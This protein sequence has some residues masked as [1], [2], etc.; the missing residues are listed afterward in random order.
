MKTAGTLLTT[1]FPGEKK[2]EI[3][4]S[5]SFTADA[6]VENQVV[7]LYPQAKF[8]TL[9]GF[10]GAFTDAAGYVFAQM[11]QDLRDKLIH[12]YYGPGGLGYVLGRTHLD[13]CDFSLEHYQAICGEDPEALDLT[14]GNQYI[15]PMLQ[16]AQ[17]VFGQPI[18][19][20]TAPWSPPAFMKTN[21]Q[22]NGGGA[23]RPAYYGPYAEYLSQYL[24][25]LRKAGVHVA[26]LT[27]Q[28]E[29]NAVQT[30][31]S[32]LFTAREEKTFLRDH[33]YPALQ[34]HGLT[35]VELFI[36]DHN[37][38]RIFERACETIDETTDALIAGIAFHWYSGDHFEALD[39]TQS[40]FPGKKLVQSEACI[41]YRHF[42]PADFLQNAQKYAHD[43]IGDLN[44]GMTAFYD[45]NLLLDAQGG[46]NHVGN[47]CDAPFLYHA[48]TG[49]LEERAS[50]A[51]LG[52]FTK[53]IT[54]GARR[55]GLSRY[56]DALDVTAFE[57][58]DHSLVAVLLN[59]GDAPLPVVLRI[60]GAQSALE[61]PG[62]SITTARIEKNGG[63]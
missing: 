20:M 45:W 19:L 27:T 28:N 21:G 34:R 53:H 56:T 37:K 18:P 12:A 8:Q 49:E 23:L 7:N 10:G 35:D 16:A 58:P 52:H 46:P 63:A 61:L 29:P 13:S 57:N 39:L 33:L 43:I 25:A 14:R 31:D 41:E 50:Y 60:P 26:R 11:P 6:G 55:I 22:R 40:R 51:Y 1:I 36:W 59:R 44:H 17:E 15:L 47:Y 9:E 48:D 24:L 4:D 62:K 3:R 38:E 32:C 54:P 30:W 2:Q 5:L 42:S